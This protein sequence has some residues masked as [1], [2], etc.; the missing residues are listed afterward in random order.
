MVL[1][2]RDL[3]VL[4]QWWEIIMKMRIQVFCDIVISHVKWYTINGVVEELAISISRPRSPRSVSSF[5]TAQSLKTGGSKILQ[6]MSI[7]I[8]FNRPSWYL[9]NIQQAIMVST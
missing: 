1:Y 3:T 2:Q 6:N 9:H 7:Y 5:C 8:T 4:G